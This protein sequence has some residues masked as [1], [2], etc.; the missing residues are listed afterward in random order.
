MSNFLNSREVHNTR[1]DDYF[2][3]FLPKKILKVIKQLSKLL[4]NSKKVLDGQSILLDEIKNIPHE[5]I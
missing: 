4:Q 2:Y 5:L 1:K 3:S